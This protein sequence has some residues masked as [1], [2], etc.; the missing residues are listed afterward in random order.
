MAAISA[1]ATGLWFA[2]HAAVGSSNSNHKFTNHKLSETRRF[3]RFGA[4][5]VTSANRVNPTA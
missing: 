2:P 5:A 1:L 3:I 4:Q